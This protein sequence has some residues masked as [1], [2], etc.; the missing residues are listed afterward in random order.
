MFNDK[1]AKRPKS[2]KQ[3]LLRP[4]TV[5]PR[6]PFKT[7]NNEVNKYNGTDLKNINPK[8][9]FTQNDNKE[10]KDS[11]NSNK[12]IKNNIVESFENGNTKDIYNTIITNE[13]K[14]FEDL[15]EKKEK[16][17]NIDLLEKDYDDLYEWSNLLNNSRPISS[18]T[19]FN[20]KTIIP[21]NEN[22]KINELNK[23]TKKNI[24]HTIIECD[25]KQNQ[26]KQKKQKSKQNSIKKNRPMSVYFQRNKSS[27]FNINNYFKE[28]LKTYSDRIKIAIKPKLKSNSYQLKHQIKT[29]RKLSAKKELELNKRL[30]VED[31]NIEKQNLIIAAERKNPIPLLQSIF[32]QVYPGEDLI[33][34]NVKMYYN[35][36][37]PFPNEDNDIP[38]DYTKNDRLR[39]IE[40]M[41]RNRT[42]KKLKFNKS[43]LDNHSNYNNNTNY[44]NLYNNNNNLDNGNNL[45]LSNYNENDPYIQ[46]FNKILDHNIKQNKD[47]IN[48]YEKKDLNETE[49]YYNPILKN[50]DNT[51]NKNKNDIKNLKNIKTEEKIDKNENN[52]NVNLRPK[53]G[54]KPVNAII[55]NPW[56]KRPLTSI[57]KNN[58]LNLN[59]NLE[60]NIN[61]NYNS[62]ELS[63]HKNNNYDPYSDYE[64][65]SSNSLPMKTLSNVGNISYDKIN[66]FIHEKHLNSN[67]L[68]YDIL[69]KNNKKYNEEQ[70][71]IPKKRNYK[72]T[73]SFSKGYNS[74]RTIN[75][76]ENNKWNGYYKKN[77]I[78]FYNFDDIFDGLLNK[79]NNNNSSY[80]LN[81]FKNF[82]GKFYSSSNNVNV[83]RKRNSKFKQLNNLYTESKYSKDE[84]EVDYI[85]ESILCK[86]NTSMQKK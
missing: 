19:T 43:D 70:I 15:N 7:I 67:K 49:K 29:Q 39:W 45:I 68:K 66:K 35:T 47:I 52:N 63:I 62:K 75:N 55:N 21:K 50:F 32:K 4:L 57:R 76:K 25:N 1:I 12:E 38:I 30:N 78:N 79:N 59:S 73:F 40:E 83:K 11:I 18:Y 77:E 27:Y 22:N 36:M 71:Y 33:K 69:S 51:F 85:D 14:K 26:K 80:T 24:K 16:L 31:I 10:T 74:N 46:L 41:K 60:K 86:I 23:N 72:R 13:L 53:T 84:A 58:N 2:G 5:R 82:G 17:K 65:S 20:K 48:D 44:N 9:I 42:E 56:G 64:Y 28:N 54:F 6:I 34:E 3:C 8:S 81:Y 37:K 61:D